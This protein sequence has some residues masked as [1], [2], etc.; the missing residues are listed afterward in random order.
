[1]VK[2]HPPGYWTKE[3]VLYDARRFSY[4]A[5]WIKGGPT[6]YSVA[7][8]NGWVREACAHMTSPKVPIGHWTLETLKSDAQKYRT[9]VEWRKARCMESAQQ[10]SSIQS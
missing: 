6:A 8:K 2:R 1:M 10:F 5:Q 3:R 7:K 4:Q 9:K